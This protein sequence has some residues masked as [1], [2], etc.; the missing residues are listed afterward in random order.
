MMVGSTKYPGRSSSTLPPYS[1][2]PPWAGE[3]ASVTVRRKVSTAAVME[4]GCE[5]DIER[6]CKRA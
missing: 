6:V 3:V 4:I 2:I 1:I 5:G